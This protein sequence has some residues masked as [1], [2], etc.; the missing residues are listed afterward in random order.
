MSRTNRGYQA[1]IPLDL[2]RLSLNLRAYCDLPPKGESLEVEVKRLMALVACGRVGQ[3]EGTEA[4]LRIIGRELDL[5]AEA[6][7]DALPHGYTVG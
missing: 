6:V 1:S 7:K 3:T 4:V 2:N 5:F